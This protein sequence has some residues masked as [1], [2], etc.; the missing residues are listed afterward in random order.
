MLNSYKTNGINIA[1]ASLVNEA[2]Y[3]R[4]Y[5]HDMQPRAYDNETQA[6]DRVLRSI[7]SWDACQKG[8]AELNLKDLSKALSA[9]ETGRV[10]DM[11]RHAVVSAHK[12]FDVLYKG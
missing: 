11:T 1:I 4:W 12:H 10:E 3:S 5:G 7:L 2:G 8:A 6:L 9:R